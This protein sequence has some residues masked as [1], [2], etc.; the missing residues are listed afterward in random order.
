MADGTS[1]GLAYGTNGSAQLTFENR[2]I[3]EKARENERNLENVIK[4]PQNV[5]QIKH[6]FRN[7][8]GHFDDTP[9]NR[10]ILTKLANDKT[11]YIGTDRY[12]NSWSEEILID[13]SQNW[14]RYRNGVINNGGNNYPPRTWENRV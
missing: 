4:L 8:R 10:K 9:E 5:E 2:Q 12:G 14:V 7:A 1:S 11:K 3:S 6:I 13:G